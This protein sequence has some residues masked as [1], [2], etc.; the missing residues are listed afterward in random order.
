MKRI[1]L[2]AS[3]CLLA[4]GLSGCKEPDVDTGTSSTADFSGL[5]IS[6]IAANEEKEDMPTKI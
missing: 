2:Y 5:I 6:E 1:F 3:L 4:A